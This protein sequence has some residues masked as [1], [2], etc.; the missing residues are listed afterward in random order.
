MNT[1]EALDWVAELFDEAPG[2]ITSTTKRPEILGWD[3]LGTLTLI[4]SLDDRFD[5]RLTEKDIDGMKSV[6]DIL[7]ILRRNGKLDDA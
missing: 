6:A 3:S 4:A 1:K 7:E 5:V 2:R